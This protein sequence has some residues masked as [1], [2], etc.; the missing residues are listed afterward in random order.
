M[1]GL[2]NHETTNDDTYVRR[3]DLTRQ[4]DGWCSDSKTRLISLVGIGGTGKTALLGYWL[5]TDYHR[6]SRNVE[7]LFFW[8]FYVE[9]SVDQFLAELL[10]FSEELGWDRPQKGSEGD[11]LDLVEKQ[12]HRLPP[13]ILAIDGLEVLQEGISEGRSYGTFVDAKL[14]DFLQHVIRAK[15]PWICVCTS[16]FPITDFRFT[17]VAVECMVGA[18]T[19]SEG[20]EVLFSNSVLGDVNDREAISRYLEGH[21][22]ALRIFAASLPRAKRDEPRR[23][24]VNVFTDLSQ[25]TE[26]QGKLVRLLDFYA[27]TLTLTQTVVLLAL[28]IFR[29]PVPRQAI[30]LLAKKISPDI[31]AEAEIN[32]LGLA[33][34]MRTLAVSGLIVDDQLGGRS[35]YA[36]HPIIRDYFRQR[37]VDDNKAFL[38]AV[39]LLTSRPDEVNAHGASAYEPL[40]A[41]VEALLVGNM[42]A[43]A[44]EIFERRFYEA[45]V[46]LNEGLAKSGKR[47][48]DA[49]VAFFES[50][51]NA[52]IR[53]IEAPRTRNRTR[54]D[55]GYFCRRALVFDL[56]LGELDDANDLI[57]AQLQHANGV[58]RAIAYH[59]LAELEFLRGNYADCVRA[60]SAVIDGLG[61]VD[62]T[63]KTRIRRVRAG[64]WRL[65]AACLLGLESLANDWFAELRASRRYIESAD[66]HALIDLANVWLSMSFRKEGGARAAKVALQRTDVFED[67]VLALEVDLVVARFGLATRHN[68][69]RCDALISKAYGESVEQS[70]QYLMLTAQILREYLALAEGRE[71]QRAMLEQAISMALGAGMLGLAAEAE[72]VLWLDTTAVTDGLAPPAD[73]VK[74][75]QKTGYEALDCFFFNVGSKE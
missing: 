73:L 53:S 45:K 47:V 10:A 32:E 52:E 3:Q 31:G 49:F 36:C 60:A 38:S 64:Y 55:R 2:P 19:N 17:S 66:V 42:F 9:R 15:S 50:A 41:A 75:V 56:A 39:D 63:A 22:L 35:L 20:A 46:F 1:G 5:K 69:R 40:I 37:L 7:G 48:C 71:V 24:L 6:I 29:T 44:L 54:F 65:K 21:P 12:F 58:I 61:S 13:L 4:L 14:R 27:N 25:N 57:S 72:Q 33:E 34:D 8:S 26:F 67:Q 62:T 51:S 59:F 18:L 16:R 74:L 68:L 11:V 70:Y 28:S 23:H 30:L 43:E